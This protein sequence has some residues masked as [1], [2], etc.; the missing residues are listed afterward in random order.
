MMDDPFCGLP[1]TQQKKINKAFADKIVKSI[2]I[3]SK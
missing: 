3:Q 2:G 1:V